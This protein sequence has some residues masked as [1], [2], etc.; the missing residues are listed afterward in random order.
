MA[1]CTVVVKAKEVPVLEPK[2][3][4]YYYSDG[5]WSDGGFLGFAE[6]GITARWAEPKPA[7]VEGK[8]VIGII[9]QTDE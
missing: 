9:F 2:I 8:T 4:D 3:G 7:P 5:T 1:E 6:D